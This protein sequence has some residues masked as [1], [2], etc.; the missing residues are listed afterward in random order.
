MVYDLAQSLNVQACCV[1]SKFKEMTSLMN[2]ISAQHFELSNTAKGLAGSNFI[3]DDDSKVTGITVK[4][5]E[6]EGAQITELVDLIWEEY[7][8]DNNG[9]IDKIEAK[10]AIE[11]VLGVFSPTEQQF[12]E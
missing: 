11:D 8:L 2:S 1:N 6:D 12:N 3:Y 5:T 10:D 4:V 7:D 9:H